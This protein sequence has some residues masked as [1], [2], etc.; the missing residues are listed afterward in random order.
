MSTLDESLRL[1]AAEG[2]DWKGKERWAMVEERKKGEGRGYIAKIE[3][4][5]RMLATCAL[6]ALF[7]RLSCHAPTAAP[8]P[9]GMTPSLRPYAPPVVPLQIPPSRSSLRDMSTRTI[10]RSGTLHRPRPSKVSAPA[11]PGGLQG[12]AKKQ[13]T[14]KTR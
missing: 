9:S 10:I 6:S 2:T 8:P 1:T 7:L 11:T 14:G 13:E 12:R 5:L 3:W 4:R